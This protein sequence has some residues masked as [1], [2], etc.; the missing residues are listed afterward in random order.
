MTPAEPTISISNDSGND[1]INAKLT[2]VPM[3][4]IKSIIIGFKRIARGILIRRAM[5]NAPQN[6]ETAVPETGFYKI[7]YPLPRDIAARTLC[8]LGFKA[9]TALEN[10]I[11]STTDMNA[12]VQAIDAYGHII[13]S[14][15]IK[16]SSAP[17]QA[18]YKQHPNN[19]LLKFKIT[20]CLSGI[21]DEWATSFLFKVLENN[22]EGLQL[23][24]L[25]SLM[26]SNVEI[27]G[28]TQDN[29]S[30]EMQELESFLRTRCHR[31]PH[32]KPG[33]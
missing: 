16:L 26:L 1:R 19:D 12:L 21:H 2:R 4:Q 15:T 18:L 6:Q 11:I 22:H 3:V 20:R 7:S 13:F 5:V 32:N 17:L 27:P 23:E 8:R 14:N 24:A 31:A 33:R 10:F 29:F 28:N 25:R 30:R 9:M